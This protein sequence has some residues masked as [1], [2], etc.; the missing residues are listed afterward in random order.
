MTDRFTIRPACV[1][2]C[3]G[4]REIRNAAVRE[5]LAIW[6]S[7]EHGPDEA[8]AWLHPL[9][10]RG[11]ALVACDGEGSVVGFAVAGP[12][13]SYEGYARTVEDSI[14]L[15]P[16]AQGRG[17][18][19]ALLEALVTASREAGDRTMVAQI[20]AGNTA[21]IHLHAKAGFELVGTIPAAGDKHGRILDLTL[22]TLRL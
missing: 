17:L 12:W 20:E 22:M 8:L 11:T 10:E 7:R 16:A 15:S 1:A 5:S 14:Y 2:D 21:S 19:G 18:G 9:V 4:V 13:Q 3:P 6:T